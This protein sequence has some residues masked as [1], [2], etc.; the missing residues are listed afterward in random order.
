MQKR[1]TDTQTLRILAEAKAGQS[2]APVARAHGVSE[3]SIFRGGQPV[4]WS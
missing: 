2:I 3:R 4:R 1:Y